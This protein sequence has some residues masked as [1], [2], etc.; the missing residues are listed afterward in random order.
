MVTVPIVSW[1]VQLCAEEWLEKLHVDQKL[2]TVEL[3]AED[4]YAQLKSCVRAGNPIVLKVGIL[5]E[6]AEFCHTATS[7]QLYGVYA[8]NSLANHHKLHAH[9]LR[10]TA[11]AGSGWPH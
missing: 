2:Q 9:Q 6:T 1:R 8:P 5:Y 4:C 10:T 11:C 7:A 3:E